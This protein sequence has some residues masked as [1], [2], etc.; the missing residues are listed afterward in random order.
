MPAF[1]L[2]FFVDAGAPTDRPDLRLRAPIAA[3]ASLAALWHADKPPFEANFFHVGRHG[4]AVRIHEITT[5]VQ[6]GVRSFS[7]LNSPISFNTTTT[8]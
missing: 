5:A 1:S 3:R 4:D 7:N 8:P 6:G 2:P